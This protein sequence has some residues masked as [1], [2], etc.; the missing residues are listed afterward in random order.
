M[1]TVSSKLLYKLRAR[2]SIGNS[3]S[4]DHRCL[5]PKI[6]QKPPEVTSTYCSR[7]PKVLFRLTIRSAEMSPEMSHHYVKCIPM[8][9][10][11]ILVFTVRSITTGYYFLIFRIIG[12]FKTIRKCCLMSPNI[13]DHSL[14]FRKIPC[15][16][17][18][19]ER[20][21]AKSGYVSV[22]VHF[23]SKTNKTL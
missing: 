3:E 10:I 4:L 13:V 14:P 5:A 8:Q 6:Y 7:E 15:R 18:L 2:S 16:L 21:Q 9:S 17:V 22:L 1:G 19:K 20:L 11:A 12:V 23:N